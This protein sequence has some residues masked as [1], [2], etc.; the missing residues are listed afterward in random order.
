M[1]YCVNCG[2]AAPSEAKFCQVCGKPHEILSSNGSTSSYVPIQSIKP[3]SGIFKWLFPF[4][5]GCLVAIGVAFISLGAIQYGLGNF[6]R[7]SAK[8]ATVGL[9][10]LWIGISYFLRTRS[11]NTPG[12]VKK[13][14]ILSGFISA[15]LVASA[16]HTIAIVLMH[17]R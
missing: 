3:K 11:W 13:Y 7:A 4:F 2:A 6:S 12:L 8:E 17:N 14:P 9:L 5:F 10:W 16:I 1:T 15:W